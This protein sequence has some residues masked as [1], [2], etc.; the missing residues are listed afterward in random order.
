MP[1][2]D[3]QKRPFDASSARFLGSSHLAGHAQETDSRPAEHLVGDVAEGAAP[4]WETAW[5]DL[6]GEG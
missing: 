3:G 2:K 4:N 5:I 6:G 1:R